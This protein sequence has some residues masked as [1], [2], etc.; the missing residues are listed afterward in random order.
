MNIAALAAFAITA[1]AQLAPGPAPGPVIDT[2]PM[3][4]RRSIKFPNNNGWAGM[5][6]LQLP[7]ITN[8]FRAASAFQVGEMFMR[9]SLNPQAN[10]SFVS[11]GVST[12]NNLLNDLQI[13]GLV[14]ASVLHIRVGGVHSTSDA[15][16]LAGRLRVRLGLVNLYS[17]RLWTDAGGNWLNL[18]SDDFALFLRADGTD[19]WVTIVRPDG[20]VEDGAKV[21]MGA[22]T[23]TAAT[24]AMNVGAST[25]A[26]VGNN[27]LQ[28][29]CI[30][31]V[32]YIRRA[33][34]DAERLRIGRGEEVGDVLGASFSGFHYR[35]S[36]VGD[37]A[38]TNGTESMGSMT[39][40]DSGQAT[41]GLFR[42]HSGGTLC[43]GQSAGNT[44]GVII[45]H[46]KLWDGVVFGK[47]RSTNA[48]AIQVPI[49]NTGSTAS[50]YE[51]R[52]LTWP[53]D[54]SNPTTAVTPW[55]Q[56]TATPL[57]A[58]ASVIGSL[59]HTA[60]P[61]R[62]VE[63][64][65][66]NDP[67]IRAASMVTGIGTVVE[68]HGQSEIEFN[69]NFQLF[70]ENTALRETNVPQASV[71]MV[72][73]VKNQCRST[74]S[75]YTPRARVE[76]ARIESIAAGYGWT[77][78]AKDWQTLYPNECAMFVNFA[79]SGQ[80]RTIWTNNTNLPSSTYPAFGTLGTPNSGEVA[81][82]QLATYPDSSKWATSGAVFYPS[83]AESATAATAKANFDAYF[84]GTGGPTRSF[85]SLYSLRTV[86]ATPIVTV[87]HGRAFNGITSATNAQIATELSAWVNRAAGAALFADA[88]PPAGFTS[89]RAAPNNVIL[90]LDTTDAIHP[91]VTATRT[92]G[93]V[94]GRAWFGKAFIHAIESVGNL[95]PNYTASALA[96]PATYGR[97][98][99]DTGTTLTIALPSS[100]LGNWARRAGTGAM[101]RLW[102]ISTDAGATYRQLVTAVT[103]VDAD[104]AGTATVAG[105]VVTIECAGL[106]AVSNA[107]LRVRYY[108][109]PM[110][111]STGTNPQFATEIAAR[112]AENN[113]I[114][115]ALVIPDARYG[116]EVVGYPLFDHNRVLTAA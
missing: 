26:V 97:A 51:A 82:I 44:N 79:V 14:T 84:Y 18:P 40:V 72:S 113:L 30:S 41:A 33:L 64:R 12:S 81:D 45:D 2:A 90:Y 28:N 100:S 16:A 66:V 52:L 114:D 98:T 15:G 76:R 21:A 17:P 71:N 75:V 57:A 94:S 89:I 105:N 73:Y 70:T 20:T 37:L 87:P 47:D 115:G 11:G 83:V 77:A 19:M 58:G 111:S 74:A 108:Q 31:D 38:K 106:S 32:G 55:V 36:G 13:F 42:L 27:G 110:A 91:G 102:E 92:A 109:Q 93:V 85:N 5:V 49:Q 43:G 116:V 4:A 46:S 103:S 60:G 1:Q 9:L 23:G 63:V 6:C 10:R 24:G 29:G 68:F 56:I 39:L 99:P 8:F 53:M 80:P 34:T 61:W 54:N 7:S 3:A 96:L 69:C 50:H 104:I 88:T 95:N 35:L 112:Q 48:G 22:Y 65:S 101:D 86:T 25:N 59:P 107:N 67:A 78:M 62:Q